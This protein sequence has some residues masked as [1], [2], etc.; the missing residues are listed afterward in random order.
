MEKKSVAC[1]LILPI[2]WGC[3]YVA[4]NLA[5]AQISVFVTGIVI[6]LVTMV[7]LTG[8]MAIRGQLRELF[9]VRFV[10]KKLLLIGLMGFL[11]DSTAFLGLTLCPAGIGTVI[12][13]TD[14]IFV[15]LIS[16]FAYGYRFK[17]RE[18]VLTFLM[19]FGIVLVLGIDFRTVQPGG[20]GN[21]FFVASAL[22]VSINAFIIKSAQHDVK[23]PVSDNV[24]A[25]YNNF[26]TLILFTVT[27]I[28]MKDLGQLTLLK[29][30][31]GLITAV[32]VASVGQTFI[33]LFYY[34]NLRRFPVWIVKV[35][36]LFVPVVAAV[37][38]F[39]LFQK[40]LSVLQVTGMIIVLVCAGGIVAGRRDSG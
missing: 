3:Y 17:I 13:K 8:I 7:L 24:V 4:S 31:A 20:A 5:V 36:L 2:I 35:F 14:I 19:L 23:N 27:A 28:A 6:R 22:F 9:H 16:I 32:M 38:E 40:S 1:L 15:N 39:L 29:K 11:L 37:I 30:D 34:Y 18:W 12:L 25:Y 21:L 33:Y 26:V 10:W